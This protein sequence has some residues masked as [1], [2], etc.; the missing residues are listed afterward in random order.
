MSEQEILQLEK[1]FAQLSP[2][3]QRALIARLTR[4]LSS[5]SA[6]RRP[7]GR[8][9]VD[10]AREIREMIGPIRGTTAELVREN[11]ER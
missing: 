5:S 7:R 6:A 2:G 4:V 9:L 8:E 3:E 10:Q 11:R 1:T